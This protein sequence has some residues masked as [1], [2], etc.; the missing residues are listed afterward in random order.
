MIR[1]TGPNRDGLNC[2]DFWFRAEF[3]YQNHIIL[4]TS[5]LLPRPRLWGRVAIAVLECGVIT[6]LLSRLC[7]ENVGVLILRSLTRGIF[8]SEG[9]GKEHGGFD[10]IL[11]PGVGSIA[12][13]RKL[14]SHNPRSSP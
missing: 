2:T 14:K 9:R 5:H 6:V 4:C 3:S 1:D 12:G 11:S 13:Q 10:F 8:Y 7:R